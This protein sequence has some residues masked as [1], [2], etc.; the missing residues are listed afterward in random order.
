MTRGALKLLV[1]LLAALLTLELGLQLASWLARGDGADRASGTDPGGDP[2]RILCV[3]DSHTYGQGVERAQ[4][5]PAQLQRALEARH[6]GQRFEVLNLGVR[7]V[8]AAYVAKRLEAQIVRYEPAVVV[9]WVGTNNMWNTLEAGEGGSARPLAALHRG[10]LNV[11]L[12]RLA[13]VLWYTRAGAFEPLDDPS[14]ADSQREERKNEYLMWVSRG[15]ERSAEKVE[16][17]L[18]SDMGRIVGVAR[19]MDVPLIFLT[20]PQRRQ[21]LPVS[22]IIERTGGELGVPVVVTAHDRQR[23]LD[24]GLRD[25]QLFVFSAGPHPSRVMYGYIVESLLP[26]VEEALLA[27]RRPAP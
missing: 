22:D 27:G 4:A 17:S 9:V 5:Y 24:D 2:M 20:Y 21:N 19:A 16:R 26:R 1:A 3:G 13:V 8:N 6:P 25:V 12:Y 10:L 7:G 14:A 18:V 23:A 11:K 15:K